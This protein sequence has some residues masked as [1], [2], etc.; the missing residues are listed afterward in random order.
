M[1]RWPAVFSPF[2]LPGAGFLL[3]LGAVSLILLAIGLAQPGAKSLA[4]P[5]ASKAQESQATRQAGKA[6]EDLAAWQ[7]AGETQEGQTARQ[8]GKAQ[9]HFIQ[10]TASKAQGQQASRAKEP[11]AA[12]QSGPSRAG[13]RSYPPNP[14][15]LRLLVQ[16]L[17]SAAT[18][19]KVQGRI[20]G[21]LSP[22]HGYLSSGIVAAAGYK[23]LVPPIKTVF[24]FGPSHQANF[25]G[26]SVL[27]QKSCQTPLGEIP[28]AG[29]AEK[30]RKQPGFVPP[31]KG[32]TTH[33]Q[34][35]E[36]QLPFLQQVLKQFELVPI[37]VGSKVDPIKLAQQILPYLNDDSLII[38]SSDLSEQHPYEQAASLDQ[39]TTKAIT[40]FDF[41]TLASSDACGKTSIAVLME[42]ARQ[43]K[44]SAQLI[45]YEN[46]GDTTRA[47]K[48]VIGFASIAFVRQ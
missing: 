36:M 6:Q 25:S 45:D 15:M 30:L 13:S 44:W 19:N 39:K 20:A 41:N 33:E 14:A 27:A 43:K 26:A 9:G 11:A 31:P 8:A 35:I 37:L 3:L 47:R 1:R 48:Q 34:S 40:S 12:M 21:L 18:G 23:Q 38:A 2:P 17:L 46:S 4:Q 42:I 28:L 5:A 24:I 10:I 16:R 22:H 32:Q 7:Q 29:I